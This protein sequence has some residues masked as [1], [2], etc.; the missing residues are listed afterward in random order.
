[1]AMVVF[2]D[3]SSYSEWFKVTI[4][5]HPLNGSFTSTEEKNIANLTA[6]QQYLQCTLW[7]ISLALFANM[8]KLKLCFENARKLKYKRKE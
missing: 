7:A 5:S 6:E 3:I 2:Y 4:I 1:M 8:S